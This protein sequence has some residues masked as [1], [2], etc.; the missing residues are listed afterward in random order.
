MW[1]QHSSKNTTS[2]RKRASSSIKKVCKKPRLDFTIRRRDMLYAT[3]CADAVHPRFRS[4]HE[5]YPLLKSPSKRSAQRLVALIFAG[6]GITASQIPKRLMPVSVLLLRMLERIPQY[7]QK[8]SLNHFCSIPFHVRDT[9]TTR[10]SIVRPIV[11]SM[12]YESQGD[13]DTPETSES[14]LNESITFP[15]E[16]VNPIQR[17]KR[18]IV[19]LLHHKTP[20]QNVFNFV[21]HFL[22]KVIPF[23]LWGCT[24]NW[25]IVEKGL[26]RFITLQKYETF[27]TVFISA[28]MKVTQVQWTS[29]LHG[30][31]SNHF[32]QRQEMLDRWIFWVSKKE[33]LEINIH[34]NIHL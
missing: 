27:S 8:K 33:N 15:P 32:H 25:K 10:S 26:W 20:Y 18:D 7:T 2:K 23:P 5:L 14:C 1:L 24:Y 4:D 21:R 34:Q 16:Q 6:K 28:K 30:G 29:L 13:S 17:H 11:A 3:P 12:D 19:H 9:Y 31:G 22:R